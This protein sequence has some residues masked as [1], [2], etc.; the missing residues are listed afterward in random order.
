MHLAITISRWIIGLLLVST[1][2]LKEDAEKKVQS[3]LETWWVKLSYVQDGALAK[4]T[5]F[6]RVISELTGAVFDRFLGRRLFSPRGLGVSVCYSLAS[7]FL[8]FQL[9]IAFSP[10]ATGPTYLELWGWF[11]FF[12]VLGTIP[13]FLK[14]SDD[15]PLWLWGLSVAAIILIPLFKITD[16]VRQHQI[17]QLQVTASGLIVFFV[18]IMAISTASDFLYIATT[19][20]LLRKAAESQS[21]FKIMR[22]VILDCAL[23]A[24]LILGPIFL[25]GVAI[26]K[27]N[28]GLVPAKP[29]PS[30][31]IPGFHPSPATMIA[32]GVM[33]VSPALNTIDFIAC[34]LF[35]LLMFAMLLHRLLWPIL[36]TPVYIV[37]RYGLLTHKGWLVSAGIVILLGKDTWKSL[38]EILLKFLG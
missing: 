26:W 8:C 1:V 37:Q 7:F 5:A 31:I 15:E 34:S 3:R 18:L 22:I 35:F 21:L 29:N 13:A 16:V 38:L 23:A 9:L 10:K 30:L 32:V 2:L 36:E 28:P 33:L 12:L 19:R 11:A 6:L 17:P 14:R 4:A 25:G 24:A 20:W 27:L